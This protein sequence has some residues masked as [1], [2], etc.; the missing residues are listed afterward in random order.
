MVADT[1]RNAL[2]ESMRLVYGIAALVVLGAA[3]ITW[4]FLPARAPTEGVLFDEEVDVAE[5]AQRH[6]RVNGPR[7]LHDDKVDR[8]I[9]FERHPDSYRHWRLSVDGPIATLEMKVDPE[10]G[11]RLGT[12]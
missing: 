7:R 10:G 3:F 6:G 2:I 5:G 11:P 8:M 12:P 4:R 1:A 9:D